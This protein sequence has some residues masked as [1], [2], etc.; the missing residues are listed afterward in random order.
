MSDEI[1]ILPTT[2]IGSYPR[3]KWL[4]ET[5][6]LHRAGKVNQE[7]L[8][9]AFNDAVVTV[10]RDHQEAGIDVPTDGEM[11]RDEMVEFFAERLSGF[12]FYGH[13]RVWGDHY[14]RKPSVT[15]KIK[16]NNP[17]LL[18]EVNFAKSVSYTQNL[19]VTITGPY[20]IS[21]WSYNEYYKT[22]RDM[23]FDLAKVINQEIKNLVD[24][25]IKVIQ[26]DE[27]A[28]HTRKEDVEWAIDSIN[29]SIKGVNVK[30]VLHVCYGEYSYLEPHLDK[31]KVDQINL[32]LKNYNY[33]PVKLFKKWDREIGVG[34][35]DVHNRKIESV[36]EVA[37]DLRKLLEYFKPEMIWVNPDCGLKLLPR[38]I[39]LQKLINMVKGTLIV[40]E[41]LKKKG[42]TNTTLKP[43]INR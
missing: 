6:R 10:V 5:I 23:A 9:E 25:G 18:D 14:Y 28:I 8:E 13:V 33:T 2:V 22:Q 26:V 30:V 37:E 34:V 43:L 38:K 42:Y 7:D 24:I 3:P 21:E 39:A 40:R 35:I 4:R 12:K 32:A 16:Y 20:T 36:E 27:P 15:G 11:R 1:T 41:E 29:E 31:L 17:M 19:K